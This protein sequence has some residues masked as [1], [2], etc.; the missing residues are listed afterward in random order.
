MTG[1]TLSESLKL[2]LAY[3]F[4]MPLFFM[5]FC[6]LYNPFGIMEYY[7]FGGHKFGFH[8]ILIACIVFCTLAIMRTIV[9]FIARKH[10][11]IRLQYLIWG[12]GE[13]FIISCFVALYTQL[14]SKN[15]EGY[16]SS[17]ADSLKFIFLTICYPAGFFLLGSIIADKNVEIAV[18]RTQPEDNSLVKFYDEHK[19]L[20]LT[21]APSSI[22]Y[23]ESQSNYVNIH[24]LDSGKEKTFFLRCSMKSIEDSVEQ[25]GLVRCHRSYFVNPAHVNVLRKET[26]GLTYAELDAAGVSSVPVSKRCYDALSA[27]L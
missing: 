22:L 2:Q 4:A 16:F 24:Y 1:K 21:I 14:F 20:K 15:P 5:A 13:L 6:L 7:S 11:V 3:I 12:I 26:D 10:K 9:Y 25:H 19:R 27:L 23:V 17:L 18:A 8:L